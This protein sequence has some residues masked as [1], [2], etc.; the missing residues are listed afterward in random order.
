[1]TKRGTYAF[2]RIAGPSDDGT[3]RFTCPAR[4][5]RIVCAGCPLSM[6]LPTEDRVPNPPAANDPDLAKGCAQETITAPGGVLA[7]ARQQHRYGTPNWM[8]S[9]TRRA[10][11]EGVFGQLKEPGSNH[12]RRGWT[13]SMGLIK[14]TL[15]LTMVVA[16][17]NIAA[18]RRHAQATG[19]SEKHHLLLAEPEFHGF[20]EITDPE[21]LD[22]QYAGTGTE[23]DPPD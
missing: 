1:M 21:A 6:L 16:A 2:R 22:R 17:N 8:A 9:F 14:T 20:V 10:R 7:K 4:A 5:G 15:M 11:I 19:N 12:I 18:V 23:P 13:R 3:E